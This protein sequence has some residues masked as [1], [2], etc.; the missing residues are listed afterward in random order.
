MN[1]DISYYNTCQML[2]SYRAPE[3]APGSKK[4]KK[5]AADASSAGEGTADQL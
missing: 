4:A 5:P 3:A 1:H 2:D